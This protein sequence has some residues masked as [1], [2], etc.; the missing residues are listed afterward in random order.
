MKVESKHKHNNSIS[1]FPQNKTYD[2]NDSMLAK[3]NGNDISQISNQS[4]D[5]YMIIGSPTHNASV[6]YGL[7]YA[8][9]QGGR[10]DLGTGS[11]FK[12]AGKQS[13]EKGSLNGIL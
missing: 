1:A 11:A 9:K 4:P 6:D 10:G 3:G 13:L 7:Q 5:N 12:R 2:I 8:D